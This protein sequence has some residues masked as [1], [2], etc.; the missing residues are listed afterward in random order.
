[1]LKCVL[2]QR[3]DDASHAASPPAYNLQPS[4]TAA[5]AAL[6]THWPTSIAYG[7]SNPWSRAALVDFGRHS[8]LYNCT[9]LSQY[10]VGTNRSTFVSHQNALAAYQG[11]ATPELVVYEGSY[12]P[13]MPPGIESG[14]DPAGH[15]LISALCADLYYDPTYYDTE[16]ALLAVSQQSG[17]SKFCAFALATQFLAAPGADGIAAEVWSYA[18]YHA[19]PFGLGDGSTASNGAATRTSFGSTISSP[20]TSTIPPSSSA[21]GTIGSTSQAPSLSPARSM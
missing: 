10:T 11:S 3:I 17:I 16:T 21:R 2:D 5:S 19:Q 18:L 12:S 6:A 14:T 8:V 7:T 20:T 4:T 15:Y 9:T 1:M 13:N